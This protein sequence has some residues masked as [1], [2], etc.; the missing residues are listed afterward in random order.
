MQKLLEVDN[1]EINSVHLYQR[2]GH[3]QFSAT[4]SS[5]QDE[6]SESSGS[7]EEESE[8]SGE[9]WDEFEEKR[10]KNPST[11]EEQDEDKD[12]GERRRKN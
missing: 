2:F 11:D 5:D 8:E 9:S 7:S 10:V 12:E 6:V 1:K 4:I 3:L